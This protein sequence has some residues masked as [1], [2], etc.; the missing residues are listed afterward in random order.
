MSPP[1]YASFQDESLLVNRKQ[2]LDRDSETLQIK[3]N[4]NCLRTDV[5][6]ENEF[7]KKLLEKVIPPNDIGVTFED[8]G[9]LENVKDT[10]KELVMLLLQRPELFCKG[11]LTKEVKEK[12]REQER[13][14]REKEAKERRK[15]REKEVE[16]RLR[17]SVSGER[18]RDRNRDRDRE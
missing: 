18:D 9:A 15:Q 3:G 11:Q 12:A 14:E 10:L 1:N 13:L 7:E 17:R 16:S 4:L 8:I 6:T 2:Q 5:V